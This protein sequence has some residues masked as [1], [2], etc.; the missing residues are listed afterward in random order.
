M[1]RWEGLNILIVEDE[2]MVSIFLEDALQ[3]MGFSI[4]GAVAS[5]EEASGIIESGKLDA[6]ILDVNLGGGTSRHLAHS[7]RQKGIPFIFATGYGAAGV[8]EEFA[9]APLLTKPFTEEDLA[10]VLSRILGRTSAP[11][12]A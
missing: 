4:A 9:G 11:D 5:A 12:K 3:E 6:A 7:L 1:G 10:G 8:P 2:A